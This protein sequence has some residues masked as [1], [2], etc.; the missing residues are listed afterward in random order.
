MWN[1]S[2]RCIALQQKRGKNP[3]CWVLVQ[4]VCIHVVFF[5][6]HQKKIVVALVTTCT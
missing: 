2:L 4:I 5:M 6:V 1:I 3:D